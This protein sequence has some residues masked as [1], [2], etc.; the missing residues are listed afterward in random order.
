MRRF[1]NLLFI[2]LLLAMFAISPIRAS[3][4]TP[5]DVIRQYTITVTPRSDGTLDMKYEFDYCAT[6][7][8]PSG[9]AYLEIGVPN[10]QFEIT[11]YGPKDWVSGANAKTSGGSWVHLDFA[12]LPRAGQCFMFN[13]TIHQSAMAHS[14]G[15]DVA[16]QF[17]PGW[18][19]F[20]KIEKLTILWVLPSDVSMVKTLDPQPARQED[21]RAVWEAQNLEPNQKFTINLTVAKAA[22]PDLNVEAAEQPASPAGTEGGGGD[23]LLVL[24]VVLVVILVVI[25]LVAVLMGESSGSYST[26]GYVGGYTSGGGYRG[27]LSSSS[28]SSGSRSGSSSSRSSGGSGSYSGRGSSCACVSCACACACAGGGRAGCDQ[29]GFDIRRFLKPWKKHEQPQT[30]S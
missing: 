10:R 9:S 20:A 25:V 18:F 16:F 6:T 4:Q 30:A 28:S 2:G 14:S 22:F 12:G 21:S 23:V 29:K 24:C 26:G 13:F 7:E 27:G 19:D 17:I 8:F 15:D 1:T 3:A 11:D 5:P